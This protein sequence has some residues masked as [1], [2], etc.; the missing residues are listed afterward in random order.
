[1]TRGA[2]VRCFVR[3]KELSPVTK[4]GTAPSVKKLFYGISRAW[5]SSRGS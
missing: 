1:M 5:N 2:S 4:N 3:K